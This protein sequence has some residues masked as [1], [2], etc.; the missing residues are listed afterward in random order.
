MVCWPP[1]DGC[2]QTKGDPGQQIQEWKGQ[3]PLTSVAPDI[4]G[5]RLPCKPHVSLLEK[6]GGDMVLSRSAPTVHLSL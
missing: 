3:Q 5:L 4:R 1:E 2:M 6:A